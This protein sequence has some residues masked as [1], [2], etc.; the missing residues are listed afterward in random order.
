[1]GLCLSYRIKKRSR[2]NLCDLKTEESTD[3]LSQ[4][5]NTSCSLAL[6]NKKRN[7][8]K[9]VLRQPVLKDLKKNKLYAARI[10]M[11]KFLMMRREGNKA[12]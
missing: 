5:M 2:K 3:K 6:F 8:G 10:Q 11:R 4:T 7:L 12:F 9:I 1:M